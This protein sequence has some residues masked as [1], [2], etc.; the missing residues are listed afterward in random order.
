MYKLVNG[1]HFKR[2]YCVLLAFVVNLDKS[3][4][5]V[6]VVYVCKWGYTCYYWELYATLG[7][8]NI[9]PVRCNGVWDIKKTSKIILTINTINQCKLVVC[10]SSGIHHHILCKYVYD[11][12]IL[13]LID[14]SRFWMRRINFLVAL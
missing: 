1:T 14:A 12:C 9:S 3:E 2:I 4:W 13:K 7:M 11:V 6:W 8:T 10:H 5:M